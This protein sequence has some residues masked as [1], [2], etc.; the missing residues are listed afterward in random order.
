MKTI[1]VSGFTGTEFPDV[2][3]ID[4]TPTTDIKWNVIKDELW[5]TPV[6]YLVQ[7]WKC[8]FSEK[9]LEDIWLPISI[10]E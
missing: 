5:G 10:K 3:T 6:Y 9:S 8:R 1:I 2:N 4:F 7:R